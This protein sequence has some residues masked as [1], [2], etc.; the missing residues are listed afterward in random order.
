MLTHANTLAC[1][2]NCILYLHAWTAYSKQGNCIKMTQRF[3]F[4]IDYHFVWIT[5]YILHALGLLLELK[6][7]QVSEGWLLVSNYPYTVVK[8]IQ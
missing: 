1:G 5:L 6:K 4:F 2:V 7:D 8:R 3:T